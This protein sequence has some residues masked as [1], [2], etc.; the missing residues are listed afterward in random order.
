MEKEDG[1]PWHAYKYLAK[2]VYR[3]FF[4]LFALLENPDMKAGGRVIAQRKLLYLEKLFASL[5]LGA[6]KV[7]DQLLR[8]LQSCD[9]QISQEGGSSSSGRQNL[10]KVLKALDTLLLF[11]LPAVFRVG[12]AVRRC[13]WEGRSANT[14]HWAK[15]IL[16]QVLVLLVHL[17]Q[18]KDGKNEYVRTLSVA[19]ISWRPWMSKIPAVCFVEESCEALLSRMGHRCDVY[20]TLHGFDHT[21][22]LFLTLPQPKRGLKSTRGMLKSGLVQVFSARIRNLVFS[23]GMMPFAPVTGAR[24]MH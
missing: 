6:P 1:M 12:Y 9:E 21:F 2:T 11:Y 5:L 7:K 16:E 10:I 17:L 13:T 3:C 20:R 18:D 8:R 19:L 15:D 23:D 14:G 4:S 24:E 22:D